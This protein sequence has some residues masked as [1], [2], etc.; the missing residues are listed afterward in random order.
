MDGHVHV[1]QSKET[2]ELRVRWDFSSSFGALS[3]AAAPPPRRR[4]RRIDPLAQKG[5]HRLNIFAPVKVS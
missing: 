2:D 5:S 4:R 3:T 1:Y